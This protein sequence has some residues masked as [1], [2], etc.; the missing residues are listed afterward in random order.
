MIDD[1]WPQA[2]EMQSLWKG[3]TEFWIND[4]PQD[5]TWERNRHHSHILPLFR[6]HLTRDTTAMFPLLQN[7]VASTEHECREPHLPVV[8][9]TESAEEDGRGVVLGLPKLYSERTV[10]ITMTPLVAENLEDKGEITEANK[11]IQRR[12]AS[13]EEDRFQ[14]EYG[15]AICQEQS[16]RNSTPTG[17]GDGKDVT[18]LETV[19]GASQSTKTGQKKTLAKRHPKDKDPMGK[20]VR[21]Y[22]GGGETTEQ[23]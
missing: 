1:T 22:Q 18:D 7:P 19:G 20:M 8:S 13:E 9:H 14:P 21:N 11:S 6:S 15:G 23:Q 2:S 5:D 12:L 17:T 16:D 10:N 3:T 4:M